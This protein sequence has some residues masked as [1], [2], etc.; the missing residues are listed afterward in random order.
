M[1]TVLFIWYFLS[2]ESLKFGPLV[3]LCMF[4]LLIIYFFIGLKYV[5]DIQ[6]AIRKF[7]SFYS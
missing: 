6:E 5:L 7:A 1:V 4:I 2:Y 3:I